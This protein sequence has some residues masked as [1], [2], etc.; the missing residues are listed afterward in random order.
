MQ[1]RRIALAVLLFA[2]SACAPGGLARASSVSLS[3][4]SP[5][6]AALQTG[7][8]QKFQATV[9]GSTDTAVAWSVQEAGGGSI[10]SDGMYTAPA[11]PGA[12]HVVAT[13]HADPAKSNSAVVTVTSPATGPTIAVSVSPK[14]ASV[15]MGGTLTF[16]ATVTGTTAGQSTA[17]IWSVQEAGGGTVDSSG[18]YT[19]PP[20]AGTYHVVATAQADSS[21]SQAAAVTVAGQRSGTFARDCLAP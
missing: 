3:A 13:S 4:I 21:K 20:T 16:T 11:T 7:A 6:S 10:A 8:S 18:K 15:T 2:G 1:L 19:A 14:T 17:V 9:S 12:Y 5:S